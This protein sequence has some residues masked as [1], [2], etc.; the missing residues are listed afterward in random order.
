MTKSF[1]KVLA[2]IIF[3]RGFVTTNF[4]GNRAGEIASEVAGV[5]SVENN[6]L[7]KD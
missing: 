6:L 1:V 7:E 2:S 5:K 3:L 4:Q